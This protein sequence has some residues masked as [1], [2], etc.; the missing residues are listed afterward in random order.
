MSSAALT[1]FLIDV[2]RGSQA[3]AYAKDPASVLRTSGLTSDVRAAIEKQDIGA[4]WQAGAHP[5][6]LLYFARSCG[7]TSEQ[8]YECITRVGA[9]VE[10]PSKS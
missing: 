6:A 7:W 5:M 3:G 4:L 10:H 9:S 2:T 1:Q 8:Y